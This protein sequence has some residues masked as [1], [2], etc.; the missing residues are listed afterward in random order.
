LSCEEITFQELEFMHVAAGFFKEHQVRTSLRFLEVLIAGFRPQDFAVRLWDGTVWSRT[1]RPSFTL[2]LNHPASLRRMFNDPNELTLGESFIA[3]DFDIEGD[4]EGAFRLADY[5]LSHEY[6]MT[7]K[8]H[9]GS[10]LARLPATRVSG[11][12]PEG[13]D[14]PGLLHSKERDRRAVTYHYDISND[15]YSLWLDRSMVYSCAY[16]R[17]RH[18]GL[19][20]AQQDKLD[21]VCKKLRLQRGDRILDLGCGWGGL[22]LHAA[23]HYGV[24]A[25][26]ITLSAPQAEL[27]RDRFRTAGVTDRCMVEVCDYRDLDPPQQFDKIVSVGMFEHVGEV[28]LPEYFRRAWDLLRPGG[29]FLNHGIAASATFHRR[30]PSFIEKY[31]FPDGE[32]V[33]IHSTL[34]AAESAGFEVR[35][36]ES[37]REHYALTLRH[38]V[39]RLEAKSED[40]KRIVG[41][42][43]YRIWRLYMAG[44]AH[45]FAIGRLNLYQVLLSKPDQGDS[46]LPLTRED[47]Y[48][49]PNG[50]QLDAEG[51]NSEV[52]ST[53]SPGAGSGIVHQ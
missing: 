6:S 24:H 2:V 19:D 47:W 25:F 37:L 7:E 22:L 5:L 39:R 16:F 18:V 51:R 50:P 15:F 38:W 9:L 23:K 27:A 53:P 8:L 34:R 49:P 43:A 10:L 48:C 28:L 44:S 14:L 41:E 4:F 13:A 42:V 33:P 11:D 30:G 26:G 32:L 12:H 20:T 35:D 21:H 17:S 40:A 45:G 46:R 29:V 1:A 31:V 3:G 52:G 36:V